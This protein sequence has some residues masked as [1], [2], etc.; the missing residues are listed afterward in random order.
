MKRGTWNRRG[1]RQVALEKDDKKHQTPNS[2]LMPESPASIR[3]E[4]LDLVRST[5]EHLQALIDGADVFEE[6]FGIGVRDGWLEFPEALGWSLQ[7]AG[8]DGVWYLPYLLILRDENALV[9]MGGYKGPP[10]NAGFVEFG[11]GVATDYRGRGLATEAARGLIDA[12]FALDAVSVVCAHTLAE[13]NPSVRLLERCGFSFAGEIDDPDDG[14][15]WRW[16][17][18]RPERAAE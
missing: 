6:R 7:K 13:R 5:P 18:Q 4:R 8:S 12:A 1:E 16:E 17:L 2:I 10:D 11:Y 9:G 15:V 14:A 3:T